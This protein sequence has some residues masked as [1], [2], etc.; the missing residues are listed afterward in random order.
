MCAC[1][2]LQGLEPNKQNKKI[3]KTSVLM[4]ALLY[5]VYLRSSSLTLTSLLRINKEYKS[6]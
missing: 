6:I 2:E 3:N 5:S 4:M 1:T